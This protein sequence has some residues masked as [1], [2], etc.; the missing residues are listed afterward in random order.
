VKM[1]LNSSELEVLAAVHTND[2]LLA[3]QT[4]DLQVREELSDD[5]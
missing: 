3:A 2:P 4:A 1:R 5:G